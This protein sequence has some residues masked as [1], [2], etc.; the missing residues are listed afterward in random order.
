MALAARFPMLWSGG[1]HPEGGA[2]DR[3]RGMCG[4]YRVLGRLRETDAD[5]GQEKPRAL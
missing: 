4:N 1:E 5:A 3:R 2:P